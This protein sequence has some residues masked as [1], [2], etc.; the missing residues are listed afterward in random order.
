MI[1]KEERRQLLEEELAHKDEIFQ[2]RMENKRQNKRR[3]KGI[4]ANK[5]RTN[6]LISLEPMRSNASDDSNRANS[7]S[8]RSNSRSSSREENSSSGSHS[9][10]HLSINAITL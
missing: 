2:Q 6:T 9:S 5:N 4:G 10:F 3:I 7:S 1:L 8:N